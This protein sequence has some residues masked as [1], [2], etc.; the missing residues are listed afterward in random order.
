MLDFA[1]FLADVAALGPDAIEVWNEPNID[2]EWVAGRISGATYAAM[3]R[4]AYV[5][6]KEVNRAVLVISA[7]P[8]PTGAQAVFP[9][10]VVNDDRWLMDFVT[11]G[12]LAAADCVGA[13]YNE[14]ILPP[15]AITGD[16]RAPYYT[17]Y[18]LTML[19]TYWRIIGGTR[20]ICFTELGYLSP[21]GL[22]GS[23]AADFA[24][25]A[26]TS[27]QNQADWLAGAVTLARATN[28]VRLLIVWNVDF[29][30]SGRDPTAGFAIMRPDGSC[31]ACL[32]LAS[33]G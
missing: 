26:G 16:P 11:A 19:E 1:A 21:E 10:R 6:I 9:G 25:A 20:P 24:W 13:H 7:A 29:A 28:R 18:F 32:T 2:R 4:I 3:L 5:A 15:D 33:A 31:P 8:A 17:R 23:L 14:G 30:D 12:G 22:G 27:V